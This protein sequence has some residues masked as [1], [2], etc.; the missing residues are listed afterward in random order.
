MNPPLPYQ[1][2]VLV[3]LYDAEGR[4]LL[5]HRAQEPNRGLYSPIGGKLHMDEGESPLTCA[6]RET[7]EEVE[8][9]LT[10][11]DLHL[12]GL[13]SETAY[14]DQTHWLLFL[15]EATHPVEVRRMTF[16]EGTLEWHRW[17]DI[18]QLPLPTTDRE[19]IYPLLRK[20]H[21][22]FFHVHIN[23]RNGAYDWRLEHPV[24]SA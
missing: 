1:I 5:L 15:Y 3:Y 22:K 21:D 19:I 11:A 2:A 24:G 20:Y 7:R 12:T 6:I 23:C 18:P 17:D 13:V 8:I 4:L 10:P 14:N 9:E 16:R